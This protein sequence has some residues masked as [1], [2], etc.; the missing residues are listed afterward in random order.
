MGGGGFS[1]DRDHS[2]LDDFALALTAKERPRVLFLGQAS[3]DDP[4]YF[5]RFHDTFADRAQ[6]NRL[7]LFDRR[8]VD[9]TAF[10]LEH[11]AIYV[12]GGNTANMLAIW[13]IHD[14]GP[15]LQAAWE[16]GVVLAGQSAG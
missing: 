2:L 4:A 3:G 13:R 6:P 9:L 14:L 7:S 1:T 16:D 5:A 15:S 10:V 12:G 11:D 8:V